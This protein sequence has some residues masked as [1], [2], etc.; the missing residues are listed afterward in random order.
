M[1]RKIYGPV[2]DELTGEW[3]IRHNQE[4]YDLYKDPNIVGLVRSRRL[5]W[6]G[7]VERMNGRYPK[8]AYD[9]TIDSR[10]PR[11][12]PKK[13]WMDNIKEDLQQ[14]E[15]WEDWRETARSRE[16]WRALVLTSRGPLGLIA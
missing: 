13:R 11:G 14:L 2:Q 1:F 12:R 4:L 9:M 15:A 16:D 10:R 7:H 3:R 8:L 5:E 6:V